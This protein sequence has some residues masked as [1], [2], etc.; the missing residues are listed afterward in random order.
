MEEVL[1]Q[2]LLSLGSWSE[3]ET[4]FGAAIDRH[5]GSGRALFGRMRALQREGK[6]NE[7]RQS[8]RQFMKSWAR[9]DSDLTEMRSAKDIA[10][11]AASP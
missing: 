6:R 5:R 9:A 3:A 8:Y 1:G 2:T 4:M 10:S 7:A 11:T